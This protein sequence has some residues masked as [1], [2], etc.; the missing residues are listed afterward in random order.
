M[1]NESLPAPIPS[2]GIQDGGS[3]DAMLAQFFRAIPSD[4]LNVQ[5]SIPTPLDR[6]LFEPGTFNSVYASNGATFPDANSIKFNHTGDYIHTVTIY[7]HSD[8]NGIIAMD[9]I[10]ENGNSYSPAA[11]AIKNISVASADTLILTALLHHE[12]NQTARLRFGGY[13]DDATGLIYS[14]W[15]LTWSVKK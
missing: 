11:F 5:F 7:G 10:D 13:S 1:P 15:S 14:V 9:I 12:A 6:A 3:T 2:P 4:T 8:K